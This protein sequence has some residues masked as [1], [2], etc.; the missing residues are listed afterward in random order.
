M[1]FSLEQAKQQFVE[2]W[3]LIGAEGNLEQALKEW[4]V[5]HNKST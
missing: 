2:F 5:R 4:H 3:R 1:Q